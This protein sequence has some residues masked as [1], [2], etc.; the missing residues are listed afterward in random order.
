MIDFVFEWLVGSK[1]KAV[2]GDVDLPRPSDK[3]DA[4]TA[5]NG[6][7]ERHEKVEAGAKIARR[8]AKPESFRPVPR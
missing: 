1:A 7:G 8:S 6:E 5:G 3:I 2:D 4:S